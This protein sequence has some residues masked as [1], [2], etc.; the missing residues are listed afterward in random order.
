M[1]EAL[2]FEDLGTRGRTD[3]IRVTGR[4]DARTSPQLM[5][6]CVAARDGGRNLVLNLRNV[7]FLSS[8]GIG[9]LLV[10]S[11]EFRE[12]GNTMSL[13][14]TSPTVREAIELLNLQAFITLHATEQDA[15]REQAA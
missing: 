10:L 9:S 2:T 4:L 8:S 7:S 1:S 14:E 15:L 13:A 12:R 11:E 6:R 3:L 5:E